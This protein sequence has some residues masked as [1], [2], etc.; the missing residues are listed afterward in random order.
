MTGGDYRCG[1]ESFI[2]V[3]AVGAS[4]DNLPSVPRLTADGGSQGIFLDVVCPGDEVIDL[5]ENLFNLLIGEKRR[6]GEVVGGQSEVCSGAFPAVRFRLAELTP[7][8]AMELALT[9]EGKLGG[10]ASEWSLPIRE[11]RR[12]ET[13]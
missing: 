5:G 2:G 6:F 1:Y 12:V 10:R 7:F 9:F 11:A 13:V 8:A 4:L 3:L